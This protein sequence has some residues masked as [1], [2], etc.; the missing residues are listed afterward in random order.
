MAAR[1]T[2]YVYD[3]LMA[4]HSHPTEFHPE[5]PDRI[6]EVF[7]AFQ[8]RGLLS[9]A[10]EI[11]A[12][13]ATT[14]ELLLVHQAPYLRELQRAVQIEDKEDFLRFSERYDSVYMNRES[15]DCALLAAGATIDIAIALQKRTIKNGFAIV[16]PPGHHAESH[17]AMG[18]CFFNNVALAAK[19]I[20]HTEPTAKVMIVDWD[21]HHGIVL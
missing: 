8:E 18:F 19:A 1:P 11:A 10:L 20:R 3:N 6:H 9:G 4:R 12:R 5:Q 15:L 16:R 2:G 13:E 14:D 21:V 17:C 7:N